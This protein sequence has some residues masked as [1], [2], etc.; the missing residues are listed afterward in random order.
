MNIQCSSRWTKY[1]IAHNPH[2][3]KRTDNKGHN[4]ST[5]VIMHII[6]ARGNSN[7]LRKPNQLISYL[8][9]HH[10][11]FVLKNLVAKLNTQNT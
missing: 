2:G 5:C 11:A 10:F 6:H 4:Y 7:M 9:I 3:N 1:E 8:S